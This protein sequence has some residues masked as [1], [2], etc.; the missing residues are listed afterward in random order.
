MRALIV[1]QFGPI[2]SHRVAD[3][4]EPVAGPGEVLVAVRAI[5]LN[6]P[7]L[8]MLQGKYQ[9]R[10]ETPF[11]PGRD[12]AG[13]VDAVGQGVTGF[14]PGDRVYCQVARGAFAEKV[15]APVDRVFAMPSRASFSE[16]AA[17][18]TPYHTAH[19][20]TMR[21]GLQ[22]GQSV[23]VTGATGSVGSAIVQLAKAKGAD[24]TATATSAD[25]AERA[26]K[27][28]ADRAV[29]VKSDLGPKELA[30]AIR[31]ANGG[32]EFNVAFETVG[33]DLAQAALRTLGY[34]GKLIIVGFAT[35]QIPELK[36]N[37]L[38]YK[39]LSVIG[40]PLDIQ[41]TERPALMK[42][43]IAELARL[44][45]EGRISANIAHR[46]PFEAFPET[47]LRLAE[48]R[49]VGRIVVETAAA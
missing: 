31:T 44:F 20:A 16:S 25:K 29:V 7:D 18:V 19:V 37:Y 30:E 38:L 11:I 35:M 26:L 27:N 14:K 41:F 4:P 12:C 43:G 46:A 2:E 9:V 40:A 47:L 23:L 36:A 22:S 42:A 39:S 10:P 8:L 17:M 6:F 49:D 28:G 33:G 48:G 34:D 45:D 1:E 15:A 32:R 13:I 3:G 24:V 5:G 21:A